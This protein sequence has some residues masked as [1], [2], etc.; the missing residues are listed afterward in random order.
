MVTHANRSPRTVEDQRSIL[1]HQI[2][3]SL[4]KAEAQRDKLKASD[5][6]LNIANIVLT[7]L[8]AFITGQAAVTGEA[9]IANWQVTSLIASAMASGSAIVMGVHQQVA[10]TDALTETKESVAKLK[11]LRVATI[12]ETYD[13]EQVTS[14]YQQLLSSF[15]R[16]DF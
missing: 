6:K 1:R 12:P 14:E 2:N 3:R 9:P 10:S 11:A 13:L 4:Q 5:R 7:S 8:A 16:V 15:H